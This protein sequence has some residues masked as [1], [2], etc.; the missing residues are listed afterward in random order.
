MPLP[1]EQQPDESGRAFRAFVHYRDLGVERSLDRA[2]AQHAGENAGKAPGQWNAWSSQ[3][4]WVR[5]AAAYDAHIDDELRKIRELKLKKLESRRFDYLLKN[6]ERLEKLVD[7]A[8]EVLGKVAATPVTDVIQNKVEESLSM[9]TRTRTKTV[10]KALK[11][12]GYARLMQ[13]VNET[14]RQAVEGPEKLTRKLAP[15]AADKFPIAGSSGSPADTV[16]PTLV[17]TTAPPENENGDADD[18]TD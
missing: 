10:V 8:S 9:A 7:Q 16:V 11:L 17:F 15:A 4:D 12:S 1:Y 2:Y 3:L 14:A 5:R 13:E 6:Q 18:S